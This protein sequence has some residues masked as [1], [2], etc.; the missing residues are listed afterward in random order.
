M[1]YF[2]MEP[3]MPKR[4]GCSKRSRDS[5]DLTPTGPRRGAMTTALEVR[6]GDLCLYGIFQNGTQDA[7]AQRLLEKEPRFLRSDADRT[8]ARRNDHGTRGASRRSLPL[9]YISEWNPR[10][11]SAAVARKGAAIPQI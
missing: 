9:W 11:R 4:S 5:S 6:R 7:E 1:V 10:C 8:S 2:R 3:K